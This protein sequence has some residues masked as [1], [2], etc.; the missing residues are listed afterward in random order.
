MTPRARRDLCVAA[1]VLALA[2]CLLLAQ[3]LLLPGAGED[4]TRVRVYV[5][6]ALK[7]DSP[8]KPGERLV[9][10]Q[11]GGETNTL[12]MTERGVYMESSTCKNQLCVQKG[13]ITDDA[14]QGGGLSAHIICLP[15]R[16][17]VHLIPGNAGGTPDPRVPDI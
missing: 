2:L 17:D 11:P 7:I 4:Q 3:R 16:V 1:G 13:E 12:V 14:A 9:L 8:L 6:G 10:S 15:H 5:G